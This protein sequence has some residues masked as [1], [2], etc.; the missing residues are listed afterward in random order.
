M[1]EATRPTMYNFKIRALECSNVK[2]LHNSKKHLD[3]N[4]C[5]RRDM[6]GGGSF[7]AQARPEST[8]RTRGA[9]SRPSQSLVGPRSS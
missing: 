5:S 3:F 2:L 7:R 6:G 4:N 9:V 8:L 1:D